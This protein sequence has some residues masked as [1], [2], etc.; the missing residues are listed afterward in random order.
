MCEVVFFF[1]F[2]KLYQL[3]VKFKTLANI[4]KQVFS[5]TFSGV[6][7]VGESKHTPKQKATPPGTETKAV[8]WCVHTLQNMKV[9]C[10]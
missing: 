1:F 2:F 10:L 3:A 5:S 6:P 8:Y 7:K 9:V 4:Q